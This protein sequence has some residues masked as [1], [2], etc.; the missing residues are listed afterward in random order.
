[1]IIYLVTNITNGKKYV[2]QTINTM[3]ERKS[4]HLNKALNRNSSTY[5]HNALRKEKDFFTWQE[6]DSASN[7]EELNSKEQFWISFYNSLVPN[8]YNL[9][10]G[11]NNKKQNEITKLKM[12][13]HGKPSAFKKVYK[14]DFEKNLIKEYESTKSLSAEIGY[15]PDNSGRKN[16]IFERN[17]YIYSFNKNETNIAN[18]INEKEKAK[19][20]VKVLML[21][22]TGKILSE[23]KNGYEASKITNIADTAIYALCNKAQN[24]LLDGTFFMYK[25]EYSEEEK[26]RRINFQRY[27]HEKK[28]QSIDGNGNTKTYNTIKEASETT[29][30]QKQNI[31]KV[32]K[33]KREKAGGFF[34]KYI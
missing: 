9:Q 5:F 11:G 19:K 8:G 3:A 13:L 33:G 15:I 10:L 32:C 21:D 17:G 28:V 26:Q 6:I 30:I 4:D 31:C 22:K 16:G 34:W 1:M 24:S 18:F 7:L 14:Y 2:G 25:K 29:G 23:F 27:K 12:K 20:N